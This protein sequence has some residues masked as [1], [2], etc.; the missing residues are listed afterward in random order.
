MLLN[1]GSLLAIHKSRYYKTSQGLSLGP[2]PFV[3]ALEYASNVTAQVIG[4]PEPSFYNTV[5]NDIECIAGETIMIGDVS[6]LIWSFGM[7]L[8]IIGCY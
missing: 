6:H 3:A 1:G 8:I 4:K 5:L 7:G 2:G